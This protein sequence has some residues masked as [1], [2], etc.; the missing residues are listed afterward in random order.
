V[1]ID[2]TS[3]HPGGHH[4]QVLAPPVSAVGPFTALA[5]GDFNGDGFADL[6][7]GAPDYSNNIDSTEQGAVYIYYGSP[8]GL[9]PTPTL[10]T[11]PDDFDNDN[12]L[13]SSVAAGDVN[14]DGYDDL[15]VGNPGPAGGGDSEGSVRIYYGSASG[16][17]ATGAQGFGS[18]HPV[19]EGEF[20][21]A[22]TL[23]DVN[24]GGHADLIVGE[25]GGHPGSAIFV[26]RPQGDVQ[27]FYGTKHGVGST[28]KLIWGKSVKASGGFGSVLASGN[29]DGKAPADVV[30]SAPQARV[31]GHANAGKIVVFRGGHGGITAA[32]HQTRGTAFTHLPKSAA[33]TAL[34]GESIAIGDL[35]GD[36]KSEVIVG[37]PAAAAPKAGEGVVYVLHGSSHG[38][39]ATGAQRITEAAVGNPGDTPRGHAD[40][41]YSVAV[42]VGGKHRRIAIGVPRAN[43]GGTNTLS[44]AVVVLR[45]SAAGV[46]LHHV[47]VIAG[48]ANQQLGVREAS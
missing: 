14:G 10:F 15:A 18:L 5:V 13:G 20:G 42:L 36:G 21:S 28:H 19:D 2:Y 8:H 27:V 4:V 3:A 30:A 1:R 31:A 22:V 45:G 46:S 44:G 23:A 33:A 24:G 11:G 38:V 17:S 48:A 37:A 47:K 25:P 32:R 7:L 26:N 41:G 12:E 9:K 43:L 40:F 34:F 29:I 35:T 16:L 6:A 39:T